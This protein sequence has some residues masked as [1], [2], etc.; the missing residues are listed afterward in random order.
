MSAAESSESNTDTEWKNDLPESQANLKRSQEDLRESQ[1]GLKKSLDSLRE[2]HLSLKKTEGD[3]RESQASLQESQA[4]LRESQTDP[5]ESQ[6]DLKGSLDNLQTSRT[7]EISEIRKELEDLQRFKA[8]MRNKVLLEWLTYGHS[9]TLCELIH[10]G[11]IKS[12][13]LLFKIV[14]TERPDLLGK[15]ERAFLKSYQLSAKE[16]AGDLEATPGM[17]IEALNRRATIIN[18]GN[19][20][21]AEQKSCSRQDSFLNTRSGASMA[22]LIKDRYE[23]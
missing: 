6:A 1:A 8:R 5:R 7:A 4:D 23:V 13:I 9:E 21:E 20:A 3:L 2:S 16:N 18:L 19:L 10:G 22:M 17:I 14:K 11:D 12:D 15:F